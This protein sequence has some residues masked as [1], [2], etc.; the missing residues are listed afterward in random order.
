MAQV[1][2][3]V[4]VGKEES[5][6][7]KYAVKRPSIA[8]DSANRPHVVADNAGSDANN[9]WLYIYHKLS[10]GWTEGVL[11]QGDCNK[12]PY[13]ASRVYLPHIEIDAADRAWI[14]CKF[15]PKECGTMHGQGVWMLEKVSSAPKTSW[16][17]YVDKA[18]TH[19]GNGNL[20]LDVNKPDQG[21]VL[22]TSGKWLK[23][24]S[25]GKELGKGQMDMGA[26]GEKIRFLIASQKG[27]KSV[28]HAAMSGYSKESS[29]Y[30][31]SLMSG[32]ITWAA[33]SA[34][35]EM[36]EDMR[37]PAIGIDRADPRRC[38][39]SIRFKAGLVINVYGGAGKM[40]FSPSK[41]P[42][43]DANASGGT[44]RFAAQWTPAPGAQGGAY[45]AYT[46]SKQVMLVY[47]SPA[48]KVSDAFPGKANP[49]LVCGG[50][51]PV[52]ATDGDGNIHLAYLSASGSK[53]R[54]RKLKVVASSPPL[55]DAGPG[56]TIPPLD[57]P[58]TPA[59]VHRPPDQDNAGEDETMSSGCACSISGPVFTLTWAMKFAILLLLLLVPL[60]RIY[61]FIFKP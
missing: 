27:G 45:L 35:K 29:K 38:Y 49:R 56:D 7:A 34:Y 3:I 12:G 50:K 5:C 15:G 4:S 10:G 31:N 39:I 52:M 43:V 40:L 44:D 17:T 59:D 58:S 14:S 32:R 33:Y 11:A 30:R 21:V 60:F 24:N 19:K 47:V 54:Y 16:F 1:P 55:D 48:G 61:S 18:K 6:G 42:V 57:H 53:L 36:G 20:S 22:A 46:R 51:E 9:K 37:H 41:L 13:R 28:W 8:V 2:K 25:A 23:L 26:S